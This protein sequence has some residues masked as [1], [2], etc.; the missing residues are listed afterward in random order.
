MTFIV[1][2]SLADLLGAVSTKSLLGK[3]PFYEPAGE[4]SR[5]RVR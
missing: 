5:V 1:I 4:V 2:H 3:V